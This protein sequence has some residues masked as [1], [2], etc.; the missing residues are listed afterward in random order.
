MLGRLLTERGD[1]DEAELLLRDALQQSR[2]RF[3]DDYLITVRTRFFLGD[4]LLAK[5]ELAQAEPLLADSYARYL[6]M[7]GPNASATRTAAESL[8]RL[9]QASGRLPNAAARSAQ[10]TRR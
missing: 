9:H 3:G 4:V 1:H 10:L 6:K 8:A 7:L 2:E 5:G